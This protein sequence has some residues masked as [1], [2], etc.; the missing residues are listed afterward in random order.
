MT[1][2]CSGQSGRWVNLSMSKY[3]KNNGNS[4]VA[5]LFSIL[6]LVIVIA[7]VWFERAEAEERNRIKP[8]AVYPMANAQISWNQTWYKG[9][10]GE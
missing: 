4:K 1:G 6:L 5:I 3:I 8:D 7:W 9:A 10:W 2:R